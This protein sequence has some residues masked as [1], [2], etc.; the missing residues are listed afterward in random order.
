M[1][2]FYQC[3]NEGRT[4]SSYHLNNVMSPGTLEETHNQT[5]V[6]QLYVEKVARISENKLRKE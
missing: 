5:Y 6:H 2:I 3:F 4:K 1:P